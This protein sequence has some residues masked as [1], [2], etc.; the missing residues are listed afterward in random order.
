MVILAGKVVMVVVLVKEE[1]AKIN[2]G[3]GGNNGKRG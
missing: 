2:I 1:R 3:E